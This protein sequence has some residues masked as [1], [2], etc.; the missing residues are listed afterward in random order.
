ML[1]APE[2]TTAQFQVFDAGG[3]LI[4]RVLLPQ[5]SEGT[6]PIVWGGDDLQGTRSASGVYYY[7]LDAG[8]FHAKGKTVIVR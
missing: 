5:L 8:G 4:W 1:S 2:P 3:R 7:K 6:T